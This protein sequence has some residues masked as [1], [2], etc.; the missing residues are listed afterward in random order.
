MVE[1]WTIE[2]NAGADPHDGDGG[3]ERLVLTRTELARSRVRR[4]AARGTDVAISLR[5]GSHLHRGDVL[6]CCGRR[7]LVE[8]SP[9]SVIAARIPAGAGAGVLMG[10]IIGN[11]HRPISIDGSTVR[12][13]IQADSELETFGRLLGAVEGVEMAVEETV[14]EPHAGADTHGH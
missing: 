11:M 4:T 12:F 5:A 8:Q 14:F 3:L 6:A 7:V 2:R 1:E 13:P 10:H 9:E